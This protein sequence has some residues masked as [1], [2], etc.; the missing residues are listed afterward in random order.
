[1][2]WDSQDYPSSWK[3]FNVVMRKKAIDI[4]NAMLK[5][6]YEENH[7]IPIATEQAKQWYKHASQEERQNVKQKT[8]QALHESSR[9]S[10]K[11]PE[12]I[13]HAVHIL[14]DGA[15]WLVKT[16]DAKRAA[17]RYQVK[18][19]AI[20]RGKEI[21]ENKETQLIIHKQSGGIQEVLNY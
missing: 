20:K 10:E 7:V 16:A 15:D 12:L 1:M 21:A 2:P 14:P 8:D 4:A 3:N 5:E 9:H 17:N 13:D 6:G 19:D 11:R 18:T